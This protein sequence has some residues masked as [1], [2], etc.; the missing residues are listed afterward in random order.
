EEDAVPRHAGLAAIRAAAGGG[1]AGF[2]RP[3]EVGQPRLCLVR[4]RVQSFRGRSAGQA[5]HPHQRGQGRCAVGDRSPRERLSPRPRA[6]G[7]DAGAH[8]AADVRSGRAGGHRRLDH[9]ARLREGAAQERAGQVLRRRR[10]PQTQTAGEAKRGQEAHEAAR[11]RGNPAGGVPGGA[12]GRPQAAGLNG[13]KP[14]LMQIA[15]IL[16]WIALPVGLLVVLDDWLLRPQRQIAASPQPPVD[17][18]VMRMAYLIL[19]LLIAAAVLR[20]LLA[21]RLDF[22]AVLLGITAVT[23]LAWAA[24]V[25]F[26]RQRR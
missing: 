25:L 11:T 7:Q 3:P 21:E 22:S 15:V 17:P 24:D 14:M 1:G 23:G 8:T 20:L 10:Q 16:S 12:A 13:G 9:R 26:L 2:L 18:W 4:L 19:P 5:R 6:G